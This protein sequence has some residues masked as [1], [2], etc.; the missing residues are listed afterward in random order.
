MGLLPSPFDGGGLGWGWI[1]RSLFLYC[2]EGNLRPVETGWVHRPSDRY[3]FIH[4]WIFNQDALDDLSVIQV[5]RDYFL[6]LQPKG[7]GNNQRIPKKKTVLFFDF[8]SPDRRLRII[9][10]HR[11]GEVIPDDFS[12]FSRL[13]RILDLARNGD[14]KLLKDLCTDNPRFRFPQ[15]FNDGGGLGVAVSGAQVVS[16]NEDIGIWYPQIFY[17]S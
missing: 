9:D 3:L 14:I 12:R 1:R 10:L 13:Q 6:R 15:A 11:P 2:Q 5:F 7:S 16:I 4:E 8:R 17:R